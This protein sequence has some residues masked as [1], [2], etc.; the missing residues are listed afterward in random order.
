MTDPSV[1]PSWGRQWNLGGGFAGLRLTDAEERRVAESQAD[2]CVGC[3]T[4]WLGSQGPVAWGDPRA[5]LGGRRWES[6]RGHFLLGTKGLAGHG[7][8]WVGHAFEDRI[9]PKLGG[10]RC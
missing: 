7:I 1:P 10:G 8:R 4:L 6:I 3:L 5:S 2:Q 9:L